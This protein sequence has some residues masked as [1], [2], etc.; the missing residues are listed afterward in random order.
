[1]QHSS[2]LAQ[3]RLRAR[4]RRSERIENGLCT[5]CGKR[6]AFSGQKC[7]ICLPRPQTVAILIRKGFVEFRQKET[8]EFLKEWLFLLTERG[9]QVIELCYGL[10]GRSPIGYIDVARIIGVSRERVRT[11][12]DCAMVKIFDAAD[13]AKLP[14]NLIPIADRL[15][16]T[17]GV[18]LQKMSARQKL[19]Y[20]IDVGRIERQPCEE[21]GEPNAE[22]HHDDYTKPL[23]V[24][25]LCRVCHTSFHVSIGSRRAVSPLT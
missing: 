1:M 18:R 25:W 19:K 15:E 22:G 13:I 3:M 14:D 4:A 24:R 9:K 10:E 20:A 6:A 12:H 11:I 2:R 23:E 16:R 7:L 21:C 5:E 17:F 8:A